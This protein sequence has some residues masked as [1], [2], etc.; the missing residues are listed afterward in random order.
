MGGFDEKAPLYT[1][2]SFMRPALFVYLIMG[3]LG[4]VLLS[5]SH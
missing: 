4:K 2:G 1:E 5:K 3:I